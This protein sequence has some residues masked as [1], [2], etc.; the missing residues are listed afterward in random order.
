M[1][2]GAANG[3]DAAAAGEADAREPSDSKKKRKKKKNKQKRVTEGMEDAGEAPDMPDEAAHEEPVEG[4][5][6][7][8]DEMATAEDTAEDAPE[9]EAAEA[10]VSEDGTGVVAPDADTGEADGGAGEAAEEQDRRNAL[11]KKR[12]RS[13]SVGAVLQPNETDKATD[14]TKKKK[15]K[16]A[17]SMGDVD[18]LTSAS[19][20][21]KKKKKKKKS[22]QPS[23]AD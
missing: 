11:G 16:R 14:S 12:K 2:T 9:M 23:E 4:A 3:E 15:K 17:L 10:D 8:D 5:A 22:Q 13:K 20:L 21:A 1:H 7:G 6:G 19:P 18:A